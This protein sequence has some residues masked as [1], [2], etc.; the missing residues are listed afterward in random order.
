VVISLFSSFHTKLAGVTFNHCQEAIRKWG[1]HDI[2]YFSLEREP[3]NPHDPNTIGVWFLND[4]LG[5]LKKSVAEKLAPVMDA[6]LKL[7]AKL[8]RRNQFAPDS[9]VGLTVEIVE[10]APIRR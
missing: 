8:V 3:G 2:G 6:G 10:D 9:I 1:R 5:Y 4:R 7:T